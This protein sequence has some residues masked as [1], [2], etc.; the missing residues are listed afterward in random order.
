MI[1]D[2]DY[3]DVFAMKLPS[4]SWNSIF[5][6]QFGVVSVKLIH[7]AIHSLS[8]SRRYHHCPSLGKMLNFIAATKIIL[9]VAFFFWTVLL[10]TAIPDYSWE[11]MGIMCDYT[12]RPNDL[13]QH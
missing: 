4:S 1:P 9:D 12:Q 6:N 7:T 5:S 13:D 11:D 8:C 10:H 2:D 3:W